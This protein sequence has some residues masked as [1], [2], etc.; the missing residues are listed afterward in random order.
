MIR[1]ATIDDAPQIKNIYNRYIL[2]TTISFDMRP[3]R[4][5][6][7][8]NAIKKAN[9]KHAYL[10]DVEDNIVRGYAYAHQW[11][12]REGYRYACET[13]VYI[14]PQFQH[15]GIGSALMH[16]LI[17]E[18]RCREF[19]VLIACITGE[20]SASMAMHEKLGFRRVSHFHSVGRKFDRWLDVV[21]YEMLLE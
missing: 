15:Q 8:V 13:S 14:A 11:K 19:K 6:Y 18:M 20:N 21:D 1:F 17:A 4:L 12:Q 10:V 2:E 16:A 7:Y 9:L 3:H 5:P